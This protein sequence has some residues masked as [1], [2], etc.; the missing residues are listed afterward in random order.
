[1]PGQ[2]LVETED[3]KDAYKDKKDGYDKDDGF[4]DDGQGKRSRQDFKSVRL[5]KTLHLKIT[6]SLGVY[7]FLYK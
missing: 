3:K 1:M 4:I 7:D 2:F 6:L 5:G